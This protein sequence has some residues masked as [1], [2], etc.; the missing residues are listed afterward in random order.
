MAFMAA[1]FLFVLPRYRFTLSACAKITKC[2][3]WLNC[4]T[5]W[6]LEIF[7]SAARGHT[8]P[9]SDVDLLVTLDDS[10]PVSVAELL[11]MA[12]EAEE[13]VGAPVDFVLLP[14]LK[15]RQTAL[16]ETTFCP[17]RFACMDVE[18]LGRLNDS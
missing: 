13:I 16:H 7:G 1:V 17:A 5:V 4:R 6:R 18:Q 10:A 11:E 9:G 3:P 2:F 14:H 15:N 12:G 8:R